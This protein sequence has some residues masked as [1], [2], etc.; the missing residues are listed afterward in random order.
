MKPGSHR[1]DCKGQHASDRIKKKV[2]TIKSEVNLHTIVWKSLKNYNF[3]TIFRGFYLDFIILLCLW[4]LVFD[5][6]FCVNQALSPVHTE[7]L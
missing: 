6:L 7:G 4:A 5:N 2:K 1:K 3:Q